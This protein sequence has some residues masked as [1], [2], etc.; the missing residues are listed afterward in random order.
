[1]DQNLTLGC[2]YQK[3]GW[4]DFIGILDQT[5]E[6]MLDQIKWNLIEEEAAVNAE[7]HDKL[8]QCVRSWRSFILQYESICQY[9]DRLQ[10]GYDP[11]FEGI[12][13]NDT[14]TVLAD[15]LGET[16]VDV[17]RLN[18]IYV[19]LRECPNSDLMLRRNNL[20]MFPLKQ[21]GWFFTCMQNYDLNKI[22]ISDADGLRVPRHVYQM[23]ANC[24]DE[25]NIMDIC[26]LQ[27]LIPRTVTD[28]VTTNNSKVYELLQTMIS[29]NRIS[30]GGEIILTHE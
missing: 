16:R 11:S 19:Y 4:F 21:C 6:S 23:K 12:T 1:M 26:E 30:I 24:F 7:F 20:R 15:M 29:T 18:P 5:I 22:W 17:D 10:D 25:K 27:H 9:S 14:W 13:F 28:N 2:W 8:P 3:D